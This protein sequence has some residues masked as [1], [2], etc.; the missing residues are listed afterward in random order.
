M[1]VGELSIESKE[2]VSSMRFSVITPLG[3]SS[4][5]NAEISST[6]VSG[7]SHDTC[8]HCFVIHLPLID[9]AGLKP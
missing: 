6:I 8:A 7:T 2:K 4:S 5:K 3:A 9:P 1:L